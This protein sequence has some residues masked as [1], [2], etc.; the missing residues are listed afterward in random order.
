MP[1]VKS[2]EHTLMNL[3]HV[4]RGGLNLEVYFHASTNSER[5]LCKLC[6]K[7]L[8]ETELNMGI[9]ANDESFIICPSCLEEVVQQGAKDVSMLQF[10]E[11]E[12]ILCQQ[13]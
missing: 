9:N 11:R 1:W 7:K 12:G 8:K 2:Y 6:K 4:I 10:Y 5:V 3:T 13:S